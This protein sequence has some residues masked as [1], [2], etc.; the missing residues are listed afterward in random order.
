MFVYTACFTKLNMIHKIELALNTWL[1]R[2]FF[3][4]PALNRNVI[5]WPLIVGWATGFYTLQK[6]RMNI[7][8]SLILQFLTGYLCHTSKTVKPPT[9]SVSR[10]A[11]MPWVCLIFQNNHWHYVRKQVKEGKQQKLNSI[12]CEKWLEKIKF[13]F[14]CHKCKLKITQFWSDIWYKKLLKYFANFSYNTNW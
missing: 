3:R 4:S 8:C 12:L 9:I 2:N 5:F 6:F 11:P 10:G 14:S 7:F 13:I 1:S